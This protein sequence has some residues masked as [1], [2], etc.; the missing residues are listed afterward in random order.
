M[1]DL[2]LLLLLLGIAILAGLYIRERMRSREDPFPDEPDTDADSQAW[3]GLKITA[4]G[5]EEDYSAALAALR[6]NRV[7]AA[8]EAN[9]PVKN[10]VRSDETAKADGGRQPEV[11]ILHVMADAGESYRGPELLAALENLGLVFGDMRIFHHYGIGDM[12]TDRPL[13]HLANMLEPGY[14]EPDNMADFSTRGVSLFMQLPSPLDAEVVFELMLNTAGQLAD[15]LGG[16]VMNQD[17][18]PL[19]E[20][21]IELLRVRV[22]GHAQDHG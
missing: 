2:R 9:E 16:R 1:N 20:E 6:R 10:D 4:R 7:S 12:K 13:F 17:R 18:M 21:D 5:D 19:T 3:D 8:D 22:R 11:F 15:T 14:F